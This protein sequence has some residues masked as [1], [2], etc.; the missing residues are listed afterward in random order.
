M[1]RFG[2]GGTAEAPERAIEIIEAKPDV[3]KIRKH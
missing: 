1:N 2:L 3:I